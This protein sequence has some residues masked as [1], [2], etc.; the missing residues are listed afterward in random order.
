VNEDGTYTDMKAAYSNGVAT[1]TTTELGDF[2]FVQ[3]STESNALF[4]I[5]G[6]VGFLTCLALIIIS[7]RKAGIYRNMEAILG[8]NDVKSVKKG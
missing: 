8:G 5:I 1:F 3:M 7:L 4:L 2:A 6:S